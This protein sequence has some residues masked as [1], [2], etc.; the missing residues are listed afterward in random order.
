MPYFVNRQELT[1][2]FPFISPKYNS[3]VVYQDGSFNDARLLVTAILTAT[4]GNG[5]KMPDSFVPANAVNRAQ[6][7]EF[8]KDEKGK[9]VGVIFKDLMEGKQFT[10]NAKYVVNCTGAWADNIRLK[11]D[12]TL[13]KRL[14]MV[15]GSHIVY[16]SK[17]AS[18]TFGLAAPS[19]DGRI[20][21]AQP[22]L[23]RVLVGTT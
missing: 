15:A 14:C 8:I 6:F 12:P 10:I 19:S 13:N 11:D 18:A 9:I 5:L 22:W 21:L 23:G 16:D 2:I 20:V 3:G 17:L 7:K 4:V 1:Q